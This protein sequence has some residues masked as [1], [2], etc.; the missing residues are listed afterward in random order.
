M[1][2]KSKVGFRG[3]VE[4][5]LFDKDGK[6]KR[7]FQSNK[8]WDILKALTGLDIRIPFV[9]GFYTYNFVRHNTFTTKGKE[10]AQKLLSGQSAT[11]LTYQAIGIGTGGTTA[12]NSEITT[13]G[14]QRAASTITTMTTTV[15]NDTAKFD[16]T[17]SFTGTFAVTEEGLFNN[18]SAGAGDMG[19]Y[20]SFSAINVVSGDSLAVTHKLIA[21]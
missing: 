20:Q 17:W 7:M 21:A 1:S 16:H 15:T 5:R 19:A 6:Q 18:A 4:Y 11:A 12:L 10:L 9:T 3:I 13:N 8:L 14:G 2:N